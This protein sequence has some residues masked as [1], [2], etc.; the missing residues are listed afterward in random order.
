M[1]KIGRRAAKA[2]RK[3]VEEVEMRILANEG[4]KSL[5]AKV[6]NAKRVTRKAVKAGAIAGVVVAATVVM[7][8]RK[9]R[10]KLAT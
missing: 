1:T 2:T 9:K 6:D 7:R 5:R 3:A 10:R 8:E 4:R